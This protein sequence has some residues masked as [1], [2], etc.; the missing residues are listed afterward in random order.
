[1]LFIYKYF[2]FILDPIL[3]SIQPS[4][5]CPTC[6]AG[7][8]A[9]DASVFSYCGNRLTHDACCC[10]VLGQRSNLYLQNLVV[11]SII[12]AISFITGNNGAAHFNP[13]PCQYSDCSFLHA[14][15][16]F[17]SNLIASC[18]CSDYRK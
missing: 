1:M 18:C 8:P 12:N 17:E 5:R 13:Y 16:C 14:N 10:N 9:C 6:G 11:S 15:S 4:I 7:C 3:N 2:S